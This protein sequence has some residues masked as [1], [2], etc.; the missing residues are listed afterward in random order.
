MRRPALMALAVC[1]FLAGTGVGRGTASDQ[2]ANGA[3]QADQLVERVLLPD[4]PVT[5]TKGRRRGFL[6]RYADAGPLLVSFMYTNCTEYCGLTISVMGLIDMDLQAGSGP[7]LRLV[8]ITVDPARDT[9]QVLAAIAGQMQASARWDWLVASP[10]DT[11]VLLSAFGMGSGPIEQHPVTYF[12]GDLQSG[13][14]RR[15][16]ADTQPD[17]VLALARQMP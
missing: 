7:P 8:L 2:D 15:L 3:M 6:S 1:G 11:P 4:I 13:L 14:F 5:D 17:Q 16:P 10:E 9:P 12:L